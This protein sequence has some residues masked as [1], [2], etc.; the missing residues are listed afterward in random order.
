M[1]GRFRT[2]PVGENPVLDYVA[3]NHLLEQERRVVTRVLSVWSKSL[4][5]AGFWYDQLLAESLGK[6][7]MGALPLTCVN[8]RDL[9]SRAQQHQEGIRDKVMNNLIVDSWRN[10]PLPIGRSEW[11][12]DQLNELADRT[13]PD[14]MTAAIRGTNQAYQD[15]SRPTTN[16]HLPA[17]DEPSLGQFF[18]MMMLAT[19]LEGRLVGIN[20][21][22]QPGVEKYK[23]NM[24]R[25]LREPVTN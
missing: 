23:T 13:L 17:A 8:S 6:N 19:V 5:S 18:Q 21:Y 15:D 1:N 11:D 22:G 3:V 20:P 12:Q 2:Q 4:E 25:L 16:I 7:E 10:D 14:I 24:N 9:H